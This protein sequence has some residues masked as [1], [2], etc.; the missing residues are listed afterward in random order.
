MIRKPAAIAALLSCALSAAWAG[1]FGAR[2]WAK[3][4]PIVDRTR[5]EALWAIGDIHGDY[6]RMLR[7]LLAAHLVET[8]P[9]KPERLTWSGGAATLVVTGDM[10]DKGPKPMDVLRSLLALQASARRQGGE[11]IVL[12]GNHEAE[13]LEPEGRPSKDRAADWARLGVTPA[14]LQACEGQVG[15]FLCSLPFGARLGDWF[16][17]HAGNT[18]GRTIAQLSSGIRAGAYSLTGPDSL[19]EARLGEGKQWI[20]PPDSKFGGERQLL[21]SYAAA[22]GVKHMVQGHQHQ[23]VKFDDGAERGKGEMFQR[24]GLLF[25]IDVGM[26]REIGDSQGAALRITASGASAVCPDGGETPL[27]DAASN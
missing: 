4:P 6:E 13:L 18:A 7:L 8:K 22:L 2:D 17:S 16:F 10:I 1:A 5:P 20:A 21:E 9:G 11:V 26:S 12:A 25:L 23:A 14:S 27:W 3:Y 15:Q 24:W 19:L